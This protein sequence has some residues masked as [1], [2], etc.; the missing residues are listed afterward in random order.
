VWPFA[1]PFRIVRQM[2]PMPHLANM[3]SDMRTTLRRQIAIILTSALA[4]VL[5]ATPIHAGSLAT[6]AK[7]DPALLAST[8][9]P[10]LVSVIV[11]EAMPASDGAE[12]L[13]RSEGGRIVHELPIIGGFSAR[14]PGTGLGRL[15]SSPAV[16]AVWRDGLVRVSSIT[17][18]LNRR[19]ANTVWQQVTKLDAV[20]KL[21]YDG[22]GVTVAL[23]DTGVQDLPD[24]AGRIIAKVDFT[25][26]HDGIDYFGHGTHMAGIIAGNGVM[27]KG[28]WKGVAPK[29]NLVSVKV[30]GADGSTDVSIVIAGLQ[31]VY[32]HRAEYNIR[33]LNLSFGT[34][35][36]QPYLVD[37][38]D[39]AVEQLWLSGVFVAAASGNRGPDG[40]TVNKPGDDPFI[41]TVGAA[42]LKNTMT[43]GDDALAPF[44][45]RGPTQDAVTKPEIVAPGVTIVSLRAVGSAIDSAYPSARI[46]DAY[47]KGTGTSQAAAVVSGLAALMFQANGAMSPDVAK[48]TMNRTAV[49]ILSGKF[50]PGTGLLDAKGAVDKAVKGTYMRSPANVGLVPS[51]G[52]GSL[53]L[54]RGS[55]RA[56]T[57]LAGDGLGAEDADGEMDKLSGEMDAL[58]NSW[59]NLGWTSIGPGPLGPVN[60][61]W[62]NLGW[63]ASAWSQSG[64]A[65][66]GWTDPAWS[67]TAWTNVGW[68]NMGWENVGWENI[69]WDNIGWDN[70]GWLRMGWSTDE[71]I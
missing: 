34:D 71:R 51:T 47:F 42:D 22:A 36:R 39:Y 9:S 59:T 37:P 54:S 64:S 63:S 1:T 45:S 52:T 58:G 31:W 41:E 38:L 50:G 35:S 48:A 12:G 32:T 29:A 16:S 23:V 6:A 53:E 18:D 44:S 56:Y 5:A 57:D 46:G 55:L 20:R 61:G 49:S 69:G 8:S 65:G 10:A 25:P 40:Q 3:A 70:V 7:L 28:T 68:D 62:A 30:A 13:V 66:T 14:L 2:R 24:L 33:V 60:L 26:D 21:G 19:E 67:G 15:A 4:T 43:T 11:R 17:E 27:S